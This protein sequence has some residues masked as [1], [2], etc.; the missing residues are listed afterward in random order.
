MTSFFVSISTKERSVNVL[1]INYEEILNENFGKIT[2]F[3]LNNFFNILWCL[4]SVT[5]DIRPFSSSHISFPSPM[6]TLLEKKFVEKMNIYYFIYYSMYSSISSNCN[7]SSAHSGI[8]TV[9]TVL[10]VQ[11]STQ[12]SSCRFLVPI[13]I[14]IKDWI[15]VSP[16][17]TP[18]NAQWYKTN[19]S[20]PPPAPLFWNKM[21]L[22]VCWTRITKLLAKLLQIYCT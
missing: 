7:I 20:P 9:L 21:L 4:S 1:R 11:Y 6:A 12:A 5:S 16:V 22:K 15:L 14:R 18:P 3:S 8:A 2:V 10:Y 19:S 13:K 17:S